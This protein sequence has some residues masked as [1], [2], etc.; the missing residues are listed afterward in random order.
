MRAVPLRPTKPRAPSVTLRS[1]LSSVSRSG[2]TSPSV[3]EIESER[4]TPSSPPVK[5]DS[6]AVGLS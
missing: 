4:D 5:L 2:T 3:D 1:S 6:S